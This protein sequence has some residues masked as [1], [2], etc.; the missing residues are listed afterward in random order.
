MC[1]WDTGLLDRVCHYVR[2]LLKAEPDS[3]AE[4]PFN[5]TYGCGSLSLVN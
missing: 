3:A 1:V 4:A 5:S 2:G